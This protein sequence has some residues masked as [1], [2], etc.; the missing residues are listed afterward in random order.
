MDGD[1]MGLDGADLRCQTLAGAAG[2]P[3]T[4]RGWL[5]SAEEGPADRFDTTFTGAYHLRDG[6]VVA[7][8]GWIDL[9]NGNLDARINRDEI[10]DPISGDVWTNTLP[11]GTPASDQDCGGWASAVGM[12]TVGSTSL[13]DAGWTNYDSERLCSVPRRLYCFEDAP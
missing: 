4:F 7:G 12:S 11:D 13:A 3:G 8:N 1:L 2:L 10:G 9:S 5:S 6:T